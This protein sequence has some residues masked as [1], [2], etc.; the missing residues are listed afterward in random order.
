MDRPQY[1]PRNTKEPPL[2]PHAPKLSERQS[3][4]SFYQRYS[5]RDGPRDS[6][7]NPPPPPSD[8][9]SSEKATSYLMA[10]VSTRWAD[11]V[12]MVN[13]FI[14]G[15]V[16]SGAYNAYSCF[17]SMQ[18][19]LSIKNHTQQFR[20]QQPA[21]YI[22]TNIPTDRKHNLP[23]P[24][25]KLP[26][27]QHPIPGL[28][29]IPHSNPLLHPRRGPNLLFPPYLRRA[30][31]LGPSRFILLPNARNSL[32]SRARALRIIERVTG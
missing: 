8:T 15:L 14:S 11:L 3:L 1:S 27:R 31:T 13:F 23:R 4:L 7:G 26:P 32:R 18:V 17:V 21:K 25:R 22:H 28:A 5:Y 29:Q 24:R 30:Q 2:R 6:N 20:S 19:S 10:D 9:S 12:L 16:D